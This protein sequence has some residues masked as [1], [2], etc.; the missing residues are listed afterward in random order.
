VIGATGPKISSPKTPRRRWHVDQDRRRIEIASARRDLAT[1]NGPRTRRDGV[2][3]ECVHVVSRLPRDE[4]ADIH[5]LLRA[6]ADSE[7]THPGCKLGREL[8]G[9]EFVHVEPVGRRARL[10]D[11]AHL[12]Q[13]RA[14]H[15][16]VDV[17]VLEDDEGRVAAQLHGHAQQLVRRLG[18]QSL[19]DG[20][21]PGEGQ[22]AQSWVGDDRAG[23]PRRE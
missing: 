12:G 14:G 5:T 18:D 9:H 2:L 7:P 19:P 16:G 10:T 8:L 22:L 11:V 20:R 6:L 13:H 23:K 1:D 17:G 3:D 21:R 4:R 15:R